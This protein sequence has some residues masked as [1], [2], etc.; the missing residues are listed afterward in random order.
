MTIAHRTFIFLFIE[1]LQS[2]LKSNLKWC[3]RPA[4]SA[5]SV[6]DAHYGV[7]GTQGGGSAA[8][9]TEVGNVSVTAR[10]LRLH[11]LNKKDGRTCWKTFIGNR[12]KEFKATLVI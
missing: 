4:V 2:L 8:D 9:T 7:K 3:H 6:G 5:T 1:F 12:Y 11:V 10:V